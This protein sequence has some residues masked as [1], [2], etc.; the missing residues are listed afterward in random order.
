M[1]TQGDPASSPQVGLNS[2]LMLRE[3]PQQQMPLGEVPYLNGAGQAV[4]VLPLW[5]CFQCQATVVWGI[6]T[7]LF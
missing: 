4:A 2:I 7:Q 1:F 3:N 5:S 6:Q